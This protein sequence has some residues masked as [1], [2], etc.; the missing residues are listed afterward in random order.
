MLRSEG[1][2]APPS[3]TPAVVTRR[4]AAV[5]FLPFAAILDERDRQRFQLETILLKS[6]SKEPTARYDSARELAE[7][8]ELFLQQ[9]PVKARP[10]GRIALTSRWCGRSPVFA[11]PLAA[12]CFP[13]LCVT[14]VGIMLAYRE[15]QHRRQAGARTAE[16]ER[17]QYV[18]DTHSAMAAREKSNVGGKPRNR[19]YT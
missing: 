10:V 3:R 18:S 13:S 11:G 15:T 14:A 19:L 12:V 6:L 17:Q 2:R 7:D 1:A 4:R 5:K 8:L 16:A 9:R